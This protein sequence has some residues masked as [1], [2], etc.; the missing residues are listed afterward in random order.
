MASPGDGSDKLIEKF[1]KN[2][3]GKTVPQEAKEA[4]E[5]EMEKFSGLSKESQ[6]YQITR[7]YLDW[8][9]ALPWGVHTEDVLCI[10]P[11]LRCP[12]N[13]TVITT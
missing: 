11:T 7:N 13:L 6:E 1:K 3:E 9:T 12:A 2:L 8:L 10:F 5:S 4:I